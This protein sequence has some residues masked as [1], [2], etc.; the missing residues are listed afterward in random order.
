MNKFDK[1]Y[2][3]DFDSNIIKTEIPVVLEKINND[4]TFTME[5]IDPLEFNENYELYT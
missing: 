1:I 2:V 4:G 3:K 5:T